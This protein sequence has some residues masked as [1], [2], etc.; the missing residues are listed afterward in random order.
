[1]PHL[2]NKYQYVDDLAD[3]CLFI[4]Q[5]DKANYQAQTQPMLSHLN[6]GSGQE[7]TIRELAETIKQVTEFKGKLRFDTT[8]PDGTPRKLLDVSKLNALGWQA[9]CDLLEGLSETYQWFIET[10]K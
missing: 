4:M 8:K 9:R 3:A 7:V 5:L 10:R 2:N 1:M 6:V